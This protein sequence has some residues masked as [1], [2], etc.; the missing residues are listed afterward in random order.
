LSSDQTLAAVERAVAEGDEADDVLRA[1]V[2]VLHRRFDYAAIAFVEE[3]E[4]VP[5]PSAGGPAEPA[6]RVP[7]V[8]RD[9][10]VAELQVSPAPDDSAVL[11]RVAELIAPHCLVGWDTG[12]EPWPEST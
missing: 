10:T 2:D 9:A 12:G 4:L 7:V 6:A 1:A 8:F 3:G 5:G 11:D